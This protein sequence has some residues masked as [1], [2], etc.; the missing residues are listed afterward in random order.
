MKKVFL[1]FGANKGQG[2]REFIR[3]YNEDELG[4]IIKNVDFWIKEN[5]LYLK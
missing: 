3:M 4:K 5:F 1:D 2:L